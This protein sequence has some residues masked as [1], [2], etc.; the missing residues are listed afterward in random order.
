MPTLQD[1]VRHHLDPLAS[2]ARWRPDMA[3]LASAP[4]LD[5]GDF[6]IREDRMETA[7]RLAKID[8]DLP[9]R[10]VS[11]IADIVAFL[12]ALTGET[13]LQRPLGRPDRVPS[14]LPVD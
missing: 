12:N 11:Q 2:N 13:A 10:T 3:I 1:M 4:W 9:P 7:R 6:V 5:S 8:I 14:G